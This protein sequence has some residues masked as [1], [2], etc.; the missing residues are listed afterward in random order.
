MAAA[1][2]DVRPAVYSAEKLP[3][4]SLPSQ[5]PLEFVPDII[6]QLSQLKQPHQKFMGF[7]AQTGDIVAPALEK[8][9]RKG[10]DAIAA[11]P[12]DLP[13]SGFGSDRN[14]AIL[15]DKHGNRRAIEP[16]SKLTMAHQLFD[17]LQTV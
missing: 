13:D 12:V 7:A 16:C 5:L 17:F 2:A 9:H 14:Q 11:N 10:L 3:K 15:I 8:L 6:A 4:R 1:V